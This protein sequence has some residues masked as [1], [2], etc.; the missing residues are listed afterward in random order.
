MKIIYLLIYLFMWFISGVG[1]GAEWE[2]IPEKYIRMVMEIN[3]FGHVT[4]TR[5]LLRNNL[6]Y[7]F[8]YLF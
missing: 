4:M 1:Y 8:Y 2:W 5:A 6:F 3:F 7:K